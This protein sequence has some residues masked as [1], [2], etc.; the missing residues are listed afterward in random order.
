MDRHEDP[1]NLKDCKVFIEKCL[2]YETNA[3]VWVHD[4][5][6]RDGTRKQ[7]KYKFS[8]G[9]PFIYWNTR[10]TNERIPCWYTS[11]IIFIYM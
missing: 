8:K 6:V 1:A 3:Y 10:N 7:L 4:S 2:Q 11:S 9:V 5:G